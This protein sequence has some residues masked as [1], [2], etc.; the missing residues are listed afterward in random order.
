VTLQHQLALA[1]D[2]AHAVFV[3]RGLLGFSL[4]T[5]F[6]VYAGASITRVFFISGRRSAP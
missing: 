6:L 4:S 5:I 3:Y 1:S 2:S